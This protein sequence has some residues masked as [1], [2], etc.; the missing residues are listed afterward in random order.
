MRAQLGLPPPER[1]IGLSAHDFAQ[2]ACAPEVVLLHSERR[3]GAPAVASRWLWRLQTLAR[4]PALTPEL[5]IAAPR[6]RARLGARP[7]RAAARR[8]YAE[9]PEP[10][11]P[12]AARPRKLPVTA[13]ER[14]VRDPYAVYARYILDLRPLDRPDEPV[15]ARAR[16]TAI[17]AAFERFAREHPDALP[18]TPRRCSRH[19][20]SR[21]WPRPACRDAA[22]AR[23]RALAQRR[24]LGRRLRAQRRRA[25]RAAARRADGRADLRRAG[26]GFT[27][28]AKADRIEV[29]GGRGR[30]ARLQDRAARRRRR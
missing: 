2:A 12:V 23:E 7:R 20:C 26:R 5:R 19:C 27:L 15:E 25:G 1:R 28:T 4:A 6:R 8:A 18:P 17:H 9:R 30:H 21:S 11:P 22:L 24:P 14:W 13:V 16:G 10:R 3:G 29:R